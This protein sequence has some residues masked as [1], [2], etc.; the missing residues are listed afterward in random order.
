MCNTPKCSE[1]NYEQIETLTRLIGLLD[2]KL[3][4]FKVGKTAG[5]TGKKIGVGIQKGK[6]QSLNER[7]IYI[8]WY[9]N[10]GNK[11]I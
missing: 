2:V 11:V 6:V 5:G 3:Q 1:M 9:Q 4:H 7:L 8:I 10:V